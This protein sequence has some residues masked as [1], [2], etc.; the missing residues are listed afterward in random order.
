MNASQFYLK[1]F[2]LDQALSFCSTVINY[3][4][5]LGIKAPSLV[6]HVYDCDL[7]GIFNVG[8]QNYSSDL[9]KINYLQS[10][11]LTSRGIDIYAQH[12]LCQAVLT[13]NYDFA[14][15]VYLECVQDFISVR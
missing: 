12:P 9:F 7:V 11:T 14:L 5:I 6:V 15:A 10:L 4:D 2:G 13:D 1:S 3:I 8:V